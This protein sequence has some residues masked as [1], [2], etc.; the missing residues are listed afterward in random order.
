MSKSSRDLSF[1]ATKMVLENKK[2]AMKFFDIWQ[3]IK[4]NDFFGF[5]ENLGF[6]GATPEQSFCAVIYV[7]LKDENSLFEVVDLKPKT[8]KLKSQVLTKNDEKII[9]SPEIKKEQKSS[10]HERDLHALLSFFVA[11]SAEFDSVYT[12]TIFHE[13]STKS[14]KGADKWLHPDIVGASF[15]SANL[16]K[17][18]VE[19]SK[20]FEK[21]PIKIYSFEIKKELKLYNLKEY[22][23]QAVSNSS[24]A[25]EGYLVALDIENDNELLEAIIRLNTS[26]GIGVIS[27]NSCEPAQS[28]II[29]QAK[30]NGKLDMVAA[31]ELCVKNRD[32]KEFLS[33]ICECKPEKMSAY[34]AWFDKILDDEE[35]KEYI[36][37]KKIE[38]K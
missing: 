28:K 9:F 1:E 8:I 37:E 13:N 25:H 20:K 32:F 5:G 7:N 21:L 33:N 26:F 34:K 31:N 18:L 24:W 27:L 16:E 10:Y 2:Q 30:N 12:K 35:I 36:K 22:Y 17:E 3:E 23:F 11:N 19:Y 14:T 6:S 29:A 15:S 38:N 4:A